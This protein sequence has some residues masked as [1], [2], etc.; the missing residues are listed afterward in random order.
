SPIGTAS[1]EQLFQL[2][3]AGI[4]DNVASPYLDYD[5]N[6]IFFGDSAGRIHRAT[7][8]NTAAAVQNTSNGFPVACGTAQ[9]QSPV[10]WDN[11]IVTA[12]ADGKIY[13]I[14]LSGATPYGCIGSSSSG[15]GAA[16]VGGGQSAPVLDVTN[17]KIIVSTNNANGGGGRLIGAWN[18]RFT[19]GESPTSS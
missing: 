7:G 12:S 8:V 3:Y 17:E 19:S 18:L 13:R 15:A 5:T 14:D 11:Q 6:Q 9:V 16:T 10:F 4:T 1:S 2:T